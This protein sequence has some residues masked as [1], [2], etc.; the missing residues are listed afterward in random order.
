MRLPSSCLHFGPTQNPSTTL[1]TSQQMDQADNE[2]ITLFEYF[3]RAAEKSARQAQE[4]REQRFSFWGTRLAR[5]LPGT[6]PLRYHTSPPF[7]RRPPPPEAT[8]S[9]RRSSEP[10]FDAACFL[11]PVRDNSPPPSHSPSLNP[12]PSRRTCRRRRKHSTAAAAA[13][14]LVMPSAGLRSSVRPPAPSWVQ[15]GLQEIKKELMKSRC[16]ECVPRDLVDV[17]TILLTEFLKEGWLDTPAPLS[18]GGPFD[19]LLVAV[20]AAKPLDSQHLAK[21]T[22][23]HH[24]AKPTEPQPAAAGS[25]EP[26]PAAAAGSTEP[27]PAAAGSTEPQPAAAGSTEPQP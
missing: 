23:P 11:C 4:E 6:G 27:Q 2:M 9:Q 25:T 16:L 10:E 18:A 7:H 21:P 17:H 14:E 8:T 26:Q 15:A 13:P 5:P 24:A 3:R 12:A 20:K 1:G 19:P 22:E